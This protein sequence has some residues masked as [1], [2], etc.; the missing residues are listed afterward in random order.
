MKIVDK[1][2]FVKIMVWRFLISIPLGTLVT[3]IFIGEVFQVVGL[4]IA[5]NIVM[6]IAHYIFELIWP[7]IWSFVGRKLCRDSI[8][9]MDPSITSTSLSEEPE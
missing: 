2:S 3:L 1:E 6:I 7:K 9:D 5:L 8:E 4:V